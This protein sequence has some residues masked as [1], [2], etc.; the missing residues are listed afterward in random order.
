MSSDQKK[1]AVEG[2]KEASRSLRG[3]IGEE[4]SNELD[5][6]GEDSVQLLKHHG[7][8]QQDNRDERTAAR[9][10]GDKTKRHSFMVRTRVPGGRLTAQ[11]MLAELQLGD[12][13]GCSNVRITSRQALQLHGVLKQDLRAVIR[14]IQDVQ[15]TTLGACGDVNRNTMCCPAPYADPVHDQLQQLAQ[16]IADTFAPRTQAYRDIWLMDDATGQRQLIGGGPDDEPLY[17]TAYLPRKFK[18]GIALPHDNCID[19][20]THDIGLLAIVQQGQIAGYNVLVGGGMGVTPSNKK[21]Y[22]ALGKQLAFAT[23]DEV[24]SLCQAIIEVQRDLGNRADRKTARLKYLVDRLGIDEFRNQVAARGGRA[25]RDPRSDDVQEMQD[26]I[27]WE[28]QGD[29]RWYYGWNVENGRLA[30][31]DTAQLK[32][33]VREVCQTLSPGIRLTAHQSILFTDIEPARR[34]ELEEILRRH[35]VVLSEQ[36]S[37]VRRWSMACVAWPTCGLAITESER[38]LARSDRP[39]GSGHRTIGPRAG[40][41]H[42]SDDR[43]PQR[44]CSTLQCGRWHRGQGE[45]TLHAVFGRFAAGDPAEFHLPGPGAAGPVSAP[46]GSAAAVLPRR[47]RGGRVVW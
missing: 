18:I 27:G 21:T 40:S 15:L 14:R 9:A 41:V 12:E 24:L 29:G 43:L 45:G 39:A 28:E 25:L 38:A 44:M 17:G 13:L 10:A 8:Y 2:I 37:T 26:H 3:S 42:R 19:V 5:H 7:T 20:Y 6:F 34:S 32:S 30:D 22:P 16:Q 4:L 11:Q 23:P 1:S 33:A 36:I 31:T 35:H 46:V 47:P